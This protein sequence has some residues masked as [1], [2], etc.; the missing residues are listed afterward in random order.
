MLRFIV[1]AL[2][3]TVLAAC[4]E[5]AHRPQAGNATLSKAEISQ[6]FATLLRQ[7]LPT[8]LITVTPNGV[9]S[10]T[11][12]TRSTWHPENAYVEY[13]RSPEDFDEIVGRHVASAIE[14]HSRQAP[15]GSAT[16]LACVRSK[17]DPLPSTDPQD[18]RF[19]EPIAG[20]LI[21][22]YCGD[23]ERN[24]EI[25]TEGTVAKLRQTEANLDRVVVE[26][27]LKLSGPV[28]YNPTATWSVV[29]SGGNYESSLILVPEVWETLQ[30]RY[31]ENLAFIVPARDLFMVAALADAETVSRMRMV[32]RDFH[33]KS[34]Y[35]ISPLL[36]RYYRGEISVLAR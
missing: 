13:L 11:A 33:E 18:Q 26:N 28:K 32:A 16:V 25:L 10:E 35:A 22:Y 17:F 20:D 30:D 9:T 34:A 24:I 5:R 27:I 14:L 1:T 21:M 4:T 19:S 6:Q 7:E 31:G 15:H 8:A 2:M 23:S 36:Y 3:L 29:T 12:E